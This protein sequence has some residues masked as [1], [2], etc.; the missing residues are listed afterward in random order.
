MVKEARVS[1][2]VEDSKEWDENDDARLR[3]MV[4]KHGVNKWATIAVEADFGHNSESCK[5]RWATFVSP[6]LDFFSFGGASAGGTVAGQ[7]LQKM[8]LAP[9]LS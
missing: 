1:M 8:R 2:A 9:A 7:E 5:Q 4:Q 6:K 3:Q